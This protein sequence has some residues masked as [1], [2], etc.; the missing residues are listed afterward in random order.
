MFNVF[1]WLPITV[2]MMLQQDLADV[3]LPV[4][5]FNIT[6]NLVSFL[7]FIQAAWSKLLYQFKRSCVSFPL[8]I[9][10]GEQVNMDFFES[11]GVY[12]LCA[13]HAILAATQV[14]VFYMFPVLDLPVLKIFKGALF[15]LHMH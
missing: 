10:V 4:N 13:L 6:H 12:S 11:C 8:C 2:I 15:V 3:I 9:C 1:L 7:L 5:I 14:K